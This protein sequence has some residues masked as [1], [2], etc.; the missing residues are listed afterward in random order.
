MTD[1]IVCFLLEHS[2]T[3]RDWLIVV[4]GVVGLVFAR[5]RCQTAD[6]NLITERYRLGSELLQKRDANG[7]SYYASRISGV[8][9]LSKILEDKKC[10]D[11]DEPILRAFETYLRSPPVFAD[12]R[13]L[14]GK[15]DYESRDTFLVIKALRMYC[16]D[17]G[18]PPLLPIPS[19]VPFRTTGRG[20][21]PNR[22]H[23]D[24]KEWMRVMEREPFY[25]IEEMPSVAKRRRFFGLT[26]C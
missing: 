2:A 4:A 11:F 6:R 14:A 21:E 3:I 18:K 5:W 16:L 12:S 15:T 1:E 22:E 25:E 20:V 23:D 19:H 26:F 7:A 24:Y 10:D 13:P 9:V 8:A 17:P